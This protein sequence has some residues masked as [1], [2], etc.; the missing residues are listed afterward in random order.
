M[1][2]AETKRRIQGL[3][4]TL[5]GKIPVPTDQVKQITLGLI[6]KFMSDIDKENTDILGGKSFFR[7]EYEKYSWDNIIDKSLSSYER[8]TLYSEGLEKMSLNPNIPELFRDI[9]KNSYLPFRDP[10]TLSQFLIGINEFTYDHSE[11]LGDAFEFLLSVMGSQG[12]AGQFRTPR[13]IIDFI[14]KVV[15]PKKTD[16]ILDPACG[17]AGFL[18]SAYKY[19]LENNK[20]PDSDKP[21]SALSLTEKNKLTDNFVG[22]DISTDM[23]RLSLVNMYLHNFANPNIK[24]YD[25]LTSEELWDEDFDCIMANPPFMTPKGG[26]KPHKRFAIRAN[27]SEVLFVDYISGHLLPNGKAGV[28]VPEG[29]IF[30]TKHAYKNLRKMLVEGGYLYSVVSLPSGVFQPYAGVKTSI[31][32]I[33]KAIANK[34]NNI[35]FVK[36]ENDGFD[37]GTQRKRIKKDDL[38]EV[39]EIIKAYK[40]NNNIQSTNAKIISKSTI[41]KNGEYCLVSDRY[42]KTV[43]DNDINFS[44][45]KLGQLLQETKTRVKDKGDFIDK[46]EVLSITMREGIIRQEEKFKKRVASTKISNYKFVKKGQLVIGFPIDEG[47]LYVLKDF[48]YGAMS[49]AYTI[50]DVNYEQLDQ[51][52][53]DYI[54]KSDTAIEIYKKF[55]TNTTNRRRTIRKDIFLNIEIPLPPLEI[56]KGIAK[57]LDEYKK[58][59]DGAN[60]IINNYKPRI[61]VNPL[62]PKIELGSI[63]DLIRGLNYDKSDETLEKTNNIVLRANNI[64]S[65]LNELDFSELKYL[66]NENKYD[67]KKR[68][69]KNDILICMASGSMNHL[70]KVAIIETGLKY[71]FGSFMGVLRL[72][73]YLDI[74]PRFIFYSLLSENYIKYLNSVIVSTNINNLNR[75]VLLSHNF[76]LPNLEIQNKIVSELDEELKNIQNTKILIKIF[77]KK[78]KE[79]I[80]EIWK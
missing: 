43:I 10:A 38:P 67:T 76:P 25:T 13:H 9:F 66:R 57:E 40:N 79:K 27:R 55:M 51:E 36:I 19:I 6:Y 74:N 58:V 71:F 7:G 62:W 35:L 37:F 1:L 65:K 30:Q 23:V 68:L 61:K 33:D 78:V 22:Y 3:R 31:L 59:I 75:K 44:R 63:C 21:G 12:D 49:P 17:T 18:I 15:E 14:V 20:A 16:R 54:I 45:I 32:F 4:D 69:K 77:S 56:Q 2:N 11:D 28:I 72:K 5:V 34:T 70:G 29:I 41:A 52:Y 53:F 26:I 46:I 64:N 42:F 48:K 24:E 60:Q 8:V 47:V 39:I 50:Y 80:Y 73:D